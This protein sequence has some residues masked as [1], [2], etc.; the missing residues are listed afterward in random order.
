MPLSNKSQIITATYTIPNSEC[1]AYSFRMQTKYNLIKLTSVYYNL[2]VD[3]KKYVL[4][5]IIV[6]YLRMRKKQLANEFNELYII[7]YNSH[8]RTQTQKNLKF[9]YA[10]R[11]RLLYI[12]HGYNNM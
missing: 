2:P 9:K 12:E 4:I 8:T 10:K 5:H 7:T 1:T 6:T 3:G 11:R